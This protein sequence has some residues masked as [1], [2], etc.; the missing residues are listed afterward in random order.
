MIP[1]VLPPD[2]DQDRRF[3]IGEEAY[4][5]DGTMIN[6]G[7]LDGLDVA[8]AKEKMRRC[9]LRETR[10]GQASRRAADAISPP[11]LGHLA[12]ALLGLPDPDD[13]LRALRHRA[14]AGE[15]SA[16]EASRRRELRQAGQ[17]ARPP[18]D[19]EACHLPAM[20]R[21]C[22]ARDRHDGHLRRF[23]VVLRA[24]LL[25]AVR[26]SRSTPTPS[27]IGCR[28]IN[29]SAASSTRSCIC[30]MRASSPAPCTRPVTRRSKSRSPDYSPRAW[31][32][33]RR[34]RTYT[35]NGCC[36]TR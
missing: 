27:A 11:R 2:E 23:V 18:S 8:A 14:G 24:L 19:L 36:P 34:I 7:F 21:P 15:G 1:V 17:P 30:S 3:A 10:E 28:S 6:S 29:I 33:T 20:R 16:G 12:A 13:P 5:G 32:P 9:P 25:A 35:E 31:S 22:D 4:T 26:A